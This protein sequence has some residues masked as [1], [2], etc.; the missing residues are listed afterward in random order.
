MT[1]YVKGTLVCDL[2]GETLREDTHDYSD[3]PI[4]QPDGIVNYQIGTTKA[5][6][7]YDCLDEMGNALRTY[8]AKLREQ[9]RLVGFQSYHKWSQ[10]E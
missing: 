5:T 4:P 6:L 10:G 1:Y 3:Y 9:G 2:C 8:S 7:C